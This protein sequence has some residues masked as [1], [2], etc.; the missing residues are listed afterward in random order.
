[1]TVI[2]ITRVSLPVQK[3]REINDFQS[4]IIDSLDFL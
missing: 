2:A 1:M 4:S 3:N